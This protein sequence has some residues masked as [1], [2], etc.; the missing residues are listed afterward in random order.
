MFVFLLQLRDTVDGDAPLRM[1][2]LFCA[3][4][5]MLWI[6]KVVLSRPE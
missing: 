3:L 2:T 6:V 5:W 4:V 1:F